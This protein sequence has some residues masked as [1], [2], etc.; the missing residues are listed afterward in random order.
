MTGP[1]RTGIPA[2]HPAAIIAFVSSI[3]ASFGLTIVYALGG[4]PQLEGTL[5][6][7]ALGGL[8][9]GIVV[10]AKELLIPEEITQEREPEPSPSAVREAAEA[11]LRAGGEQIT[12]H[13]LLAR[14]LLAT[15]GALGLAAVFPIRSLGPSPGRSLFHT[16]WTP[17]ALVVDDVG[18]ALGI[19]DLEIDS[20]VTVF[21]EGHVG[22]PVSQ[23]LL[24]RVEPD[25]LTLPPERLAWAPQ[26]YIAFSKIC[27]H[28]GCPVGLYEAR[29]HLLL[30]P[31]HQSTFDVLRGAARVFGPA[32]RSLPQLPLMVGADGLL[33]ARSDFMEPVGPGF[34]DRP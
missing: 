18:R 12:R 14:L 32:T 27:T 2:P 3:L 29:S 24:I 17:G 11:A 10:W 1:A 28:V 19:H 23:S 31:C 21:P 8:G 33:R 22:S 5:L 25:S 4:Q 30:C 15:L 20:V 9:I 13:R 6:A 34:W 26:G 7:V 16:E